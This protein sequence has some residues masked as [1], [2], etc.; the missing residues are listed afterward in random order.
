MFQTAQPVHRMGSRGQL[1]TR[2]DQPTL[3]QQPTTFAHQRNSL[4]IKSTVQT[5]GIPGSTKNRKP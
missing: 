2:S 1:T 3:P 5:Y 4:R